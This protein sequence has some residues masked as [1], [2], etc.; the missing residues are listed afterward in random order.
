MAAAIVLFHRPGRERFA[1]FADLLGGHGLTMQ[2]R[3]RRRAYDQCHRFDVGFYAGLPGV[4]AAHDHTRDPCIGRIQHPG[5]IGRCI[6]PKG[7]DRAVA[8]S[9][10]ARTANTLGGI[11]F[12]RRGT[13]VVNRRVQE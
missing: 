5:L 9:G 10:A 3:I 4:Q 6:E 7:S 12:A 13:S 8:C 1:F 11:A 2:E